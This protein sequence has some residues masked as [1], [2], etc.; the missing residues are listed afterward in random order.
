MERL[1]QK[2]LPH[3][4]T[5]DKGSCREPVVHAANQPRQT[6]GITLGISD[7]FRCPI[8]R[9]SFPTVKSHHPAVQKLDANAKKF[10]TGRPRV[11]KIESSIRVGS[12]RA[13]NEQQI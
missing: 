5:F 4:R 3:I 7:D 10:D 12:H 1:A 11:H 8:N 6:A 9:T 13:G 2:E